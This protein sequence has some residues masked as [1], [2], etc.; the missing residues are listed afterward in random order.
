MK[1]FLQPWKLA[2]VLMFLMIFSSLFAFIYTEQVKLPSENWSNQLEIDAYNPKMDFESLSSNN[3]TAIAIDETRFINVVALDNTLM[4]KMFNIYGVELNTGEAT[5][6]HNITEVSGMLVNERLELI[7]LSESNDKVSFL[8]IQ[9]ED[10][11]EM[12]RKEVTLEGMTFKLSSNHVAAYDRTKVA[13]IK[14]GTTTIYEPDF[15]GR[16]ELAE[17]DYIDGQAVVAAITMQGS[18]YKLS[19]MTDN[20]SDVFTENLHIL[21]SLSAINPVN[22]TMAIDEGKAIVISTMKHMRF[23]NNYVDF[24]NFDTKDP[25]SYEHTGYEVDTYEAVPYLIREDNGQ[26]SYLINFWASNLGRTEIAKGVQ[27]YPNLYKTT[28]GTDEFKQLT[29]SERSSVKP[30]YLKMGQYEYLVHNEQNDLENKV[31]LSSND[32]EMIASSRDY[33]Q[34]TLMDIF[35]RTIT[36]YPALILAGIPPMMTVILPLLVFTAP[37][38]MFKLNWAEQ[39]KEKMTLILLG[40]FLASKTYTFGFDIFKFFT[41]EGLW[42]PFLETSTSHWTAYAL[43]SALTLFVYINRKKTREGK[44][45]HFLKS[46]SFYVIL[47][48]VI[49]ITFFMPYSII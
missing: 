18:T 48:L 21:P 37:I 15:D 16:I 24:F 11:S 7:T 42:P 1:K 46:I 5:F 34:S 26:L 28:H 12:D 9:P 27:A 32:P 4:F 23:G 33:S 19:V 29:K 36:T 44:N 35:L 14:D 47:D 49:M 6:D 10:F 43:F 41:N 13:I 31:Y 22:V 3:T 30:S 38:L 17:V 40:V 39:N 25:L 45:D 8:T 20:G 2:I